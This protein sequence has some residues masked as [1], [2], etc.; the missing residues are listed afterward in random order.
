MVEKAYTFCTVFITLLGLRV[1]KFDLKSKT[2]PGSKSR[3]TF[4]KDTLKEFFETIY[5]IS[6]IV[7]ST[8]VILLCLN[9]C[10][11]LLAFEEPFHRSAGTMLLFPITFLPLWFIQAVC[12]QKKIRNFSRNLSCLVKLMN[13]QDRNCIPRSSLGLFIAGFACFLF[14]MTTFYASAI[15]Q[16]YF[17][18]ESQLP[19]ALIIFPLQSFACFLI[20]VVFHILILIAAHFF[21]VIVSETAYSSKESKSSFNIDS[22]GSEMSKRN[23]DCFETLNDLKVQI[24]LLDHCQDLIMSIFCLP[25]LAINLVMM[26]SLCF[27]I[28]LT[29]DAFLTGQPIYY[30][31]GLFL[32]IPWTSLF[33]L[34][35]HYS[36]DIF[37]MKVR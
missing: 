4:F 32:A 14:N 11:K 3:E 16:N 1:P 5:Y 36:A 10:W 12:N 21:E 17:S 7:V 33:L 8:T 20:I 22:P 30:V 28:Y 25:L 27:G 37:R 29:L 13:K 35:L 24:L 9:E 31:I 15:K 6:L 34:T 23:L 2:R 19:F 26:L 18:I